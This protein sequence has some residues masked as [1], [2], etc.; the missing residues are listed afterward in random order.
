MADISAGEDTTGRRR[1]WRHR[2]NRASSKLVAKRVSEEDHSALTR[3]A[4]A[5]GVKV[6]ELLAPAVEDLIQRAHEFCDHDDAPAQAVK[7]S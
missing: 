5:Q 3:Y 7:A 6:A 4:E 2:E 1:N